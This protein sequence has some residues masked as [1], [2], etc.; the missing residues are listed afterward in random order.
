MQR[1]P[2]PH[3]DALFSGATLILPLP[4]SIYFFN[5]RCCLPTMHTAATSSLCYLA[6]VSDSVPRQLSHQPATPETWAVRLCSMLKGPQT[7]ESN[8]LGSTSPLPVSSYLTLQ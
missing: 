2:S 7:L 8:C 5:S 4:L 1:V 3:L 6:Q